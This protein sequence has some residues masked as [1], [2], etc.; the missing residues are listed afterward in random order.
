MKLNRSIFVRSFVLISLITSL[1][2]LS[3]R[4]QADT[5]T[6]GGVTITLPFNDVMASPFFCQIAA[7]YYSG[8]ANGTTATTYSPTTVV[9][10][11]QMAAFTTRTLDQSLKRGSRKAVAR[12]WWTPQDANSLALTD[13]GDSPGAVEFDGTDLWMANHGNGTATAMRIRPSDGKVLDTWTG[14]INPTG[15]L[16][17]MGKVFIT[18]QI[19]PG[20]LYMID[21]TQ[22]AGVVTT[23]TSSLGDGSFGIAFDGTRIWTANL[24][25]SVS[26]VTL[27]PTTV[28]TVST[29]FSSPFGVLYDGSNIWIAD[30]GDG[31]IKKLDS[32][33]A[34]LQSITVGTGPCQPVFDGIN[35]W[36]PNRL[37][38]SVSVVR[39]KD[40][41]GNPLASAFLVATLTGNGLNEPFTA[42]FD[43]ERILI[44]NRSGGSVSLWKAVDLTP[45]GTFPTGFN[46]APS[47]ACSDG[48]NFWITLRNTDKLA[49]F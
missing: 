30:Q 35:I 46:T 11:E 21:P 45:L 32:S 25:A 7:S 10:R 5:G 39:V 13:V 42:A 9:T 44:T 20:R 19:S 38:N 33:G 18:G 28:T 26:I 15:I 1:T 41:T 12:K 2:V 17:A 16:C 37:S 29:G 8:L 24:G 22:P 3:T 40:A 23:L 43:S 49:R 34:I 6:C 47:G 14:D 31:S 36:V 27:N 4:L 48:L